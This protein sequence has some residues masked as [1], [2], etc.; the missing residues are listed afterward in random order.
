M[1]TNELLNIENRIYLIQEYESQAKNAME[2]A[3]ALKAS[4]KDDMSRKGLEEIK[5]PN[6]IV[7]WVDILSSR[8]DTKRFKEDMGEDIYNFYTKQVPSRRFT[9]SS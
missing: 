5:T 6:F 9:I 7:K 8:F 4:I 1:S 3:E 2:K